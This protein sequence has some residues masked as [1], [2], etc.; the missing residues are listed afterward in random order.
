MQLFHDELGLSA[1]H[2]D[3]DTTTG[4]FEGNCVWKVDRWLLIGLEW[5]IVS[6]TSFLFYLLVSGKG[7]GEPNS[8]AD[9]ISS[10]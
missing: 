5:F 7:S 6:C 9:W 10:V 1:A 3:L 4:S 8:E 2:N